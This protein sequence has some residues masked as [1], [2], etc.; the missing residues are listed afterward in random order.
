MVAEPGT[1]STGDDASWTFENQREIFKE[2]EEYE[3]IV[4][5]EFRSYLTHL[6]NH[7]KPL[8]EA[9]HIKLLVDEAVPG[10]YKEDDAQRVIVAAHQMNA[11]KVHSD[12]IR[13]LTNRW[14]TPG[15]VG[16]VGSVSAGKKENVKTDNFVPKLTLD[17]RLFRRVV[18]FSGDLSKYRGWLFDLLVAIRQGI[19]K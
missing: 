17:E 7:N 6:E 10:N 16:P 8:Y 13:R 15:L 3:K 18:V 9:V 1:S 5:L 4:N 19:C 11:I 14:L 12:N 2:S